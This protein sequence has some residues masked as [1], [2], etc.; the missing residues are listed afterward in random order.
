MACSR[1]VRICGDTVDVRLLPW[2]LQLILLLYLM[3]PAFVKR[4]HRKQGV[5][6]IRSNLANILLEWLIARKVINVYRNAMV[7]W[8]FSVN[9]E[10]LRVAGLTRFLS[11]TLC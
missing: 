3:N 9:L 5:I 6:P 2:V 7:P 8:I 4:D 1:H 10:V 11:R